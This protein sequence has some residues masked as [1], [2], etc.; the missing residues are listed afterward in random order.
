M[1]RHAITLVITMAG[2][3][4]LGGCGH[5]PQTHLLALDLAPPAMRP[6]PAY[7]GPPLRVT[8]VHI[9]ASIDRL[10]FALATSPTELQL[11]D[12]YHWSASLGSLA[13]DALLRDLI[14]R[15]PSAMVLPPDSPATKGVR[16]VDVTLLDL[17]T[18]SADTTMEVLITMGTDG[19]AG[20]IR[21][22]AH[23]TRRH[24]EN[25]SPSQSAADYSS[26]L[27]EVADTIVSMG[28]PPVRSSE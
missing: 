15:L 12:Q 5:S 22:Q 1:N 25:Q 13:R 16:R 24:A 18:A 23:F 10:E 6:D 11:Q 28:A 27:G 17:T 20:V 4:M 2:L 26:M 9:P 3:F 8:A 14:A 21:R 7:A 19:E